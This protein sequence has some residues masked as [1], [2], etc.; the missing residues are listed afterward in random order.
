MRGSNSR[1]ALSILYGPKLR[2]RSRERPTRPWR[3]QVVPAPGDGHVLEDTVVESCADRRVLAHVGAVHRLAGVD[4]VG[5]RPLQREEVQARLAAVENESVDVRNPDAA[6]TVS[7]LAARIQA[8]ER[9][10]NETG[11]TA[12]SIGVNTT[13]LDALRS[14]ASKLRGH[15]VAS[16]A[17][18]LSGGPPAEI[19]G[20]PPAEALGPSNESAGN[21]PTDGG[22]KTPPGASDTSPPGASETASKPDDSGTDRPGRNEEMTK[23]PTERGD[24][25]ERTTTSP[26]SLSQM[27]ATAAFEWSRGSN[28]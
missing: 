10:M 9:A 12:R 23:Q 15:E 8:L 2:V 21:G 28:L 24:G 26:N 22:G 6:A 7:R 25:T 5:D 3:E 17:R 19:P 16:M 1:R 14:E 18:N 20:G 4:E 13:R 11:E 27:D